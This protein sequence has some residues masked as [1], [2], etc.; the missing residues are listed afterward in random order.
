MQDSIRQLGD[1]AD[2]G[3]SGQTAHKHPKRQHRDRGDKQLQD[4]NDKGVC[5]PHKR[6]NHQVHDHQRPHEDI[7]KLCQPV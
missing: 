5:L 6:G 2:G 1:N 4:S 3:L 7:L